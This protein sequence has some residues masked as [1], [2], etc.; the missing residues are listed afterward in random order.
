[1]IMK[2]DSSVGLKSPSL[3]IKPKHKPK[4]LKQHKKAQVKTQKALQIIK[5]GIE[6]IA[7]TK[8]AASQSIKTTSSKSRAVR[9]T[10]TGRS[11]INQRLRKKSV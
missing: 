6:K 4:A 1:M 7:N 2:D 11:S 10:K 8:P 9:N 3:S 5:K